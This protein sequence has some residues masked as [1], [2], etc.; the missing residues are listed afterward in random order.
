MSTAI[1]RGDTGIPL[2]IIETDNYA[3]WLEKRPVDDKNW[4]NNSGYQGDGIGLI[5]DISG[6]IAGVVF[7]VKSV[8]DYYIC[9]D[10]PKQLPSGDYY[11][12]ADEGLQ[13]RAAFSWCLGSYQFTRYKKDRDQQ[14]EFAVLVVQSLTAV[15]NAQRLFAAISLVRD[16]IN[17]PAEDMMPEHLAEAVIGMAKPF[18]A[19]VTQIVGD[20][21]L[22]KN[23]PTIHSV[24]R[25]S[26][27]APRLI[28]LRWGDDSHPKVTLVGKGVCFDSGGLNLKP[29][30][31]IR[32]M[33]KDMAGAANVLGLAHLIMSN[34]LPIR[35]RVLIPAV[36]NAIGSNALRPGDIITTRKGITVE[37]DNTDAEGRLVLCDAL[38]EA[39]N[40]KPDMLIDFATLTGVNSAALGGDMVGLYANDIALSRE[41]ADLGA[42]IDDPGWPMPIY[43]PYEYQL[44]SEVADTLNRSTH[45]L[46]G[47]IT[48]ALYLNKFVDEDINWLHIDFIAWNDRKRPGRPVGGDAYGVRA[49]LAYLQKRYQS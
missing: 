8:A 44:N 43:K 10:L 6:K 47:A 40:E 12:Q 33:K 21:L 46:G 11:L 23:Y 18:G 20:E 7:G 42:G 36:E 4:L 22:A 37:I 5:P 3:A 26:V 25:A 19:A 45:K 16:L 14:Q 38:A 34:R 41:I 15:E 27:H 17:T 24:G 49:L 28:D 32:R 39:C 13:A 30:E 9:G 35:L 48:A 2:T 29:A 1:V 31:G